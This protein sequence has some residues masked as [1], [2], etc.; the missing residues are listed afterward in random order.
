M[1]KMRHK[2]RPKCKGTFESV[3]MNM[4]FDWKLQIETSKNNK[5]QCETC[6]LGNHQHKTTSI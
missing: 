6:I 2:I 3:K 4:V 1:T 5:N